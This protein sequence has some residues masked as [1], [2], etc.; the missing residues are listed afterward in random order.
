[1]K[2][3]LLN[4]GIIMLMYKIIQVINGLSLSFTSHALLLNSKL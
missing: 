3:R 4:Q 1:M 2:D